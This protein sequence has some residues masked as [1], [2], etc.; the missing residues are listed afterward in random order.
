MANKK[1]TILIVL[2][3]FNIFTWLI[4]YNYDR[5]Q[6]LEVIFFD[7][8]QGDAV[9]IETPLNYQILIDGG[10]SSAILNKLGKEID[11]W[12]RTIDLI[13]L[14][15]PEHDHIAG[16]IEVLKRYNVENILWTGVLRDTGEYDEWTRL[17][18]DSNVEIAQ[19]GQKI[20]APNIFFE[21]LYPFENLEGQ[22]VKNTNNS[23]IVSRLVFNDTCFIFTGDIYSSVERKIIDKQLD[24]DCEVLKIGH[25]GSKTS[26]SK[27]L[28][29]NVTPQIAVISAGKD[30][31]YG[32]PHD[33]VLEILTDY[34]IK[35]LR[36]DQLGDIK[37]IS[38]GDNVT[39]T[40]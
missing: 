8:G 18:E 9:F 6:L 29:E 17:I 24:L 30:N 31:S 36:T 35:V 23:S 32:H 21:I 25:H 12:D 28:L 2:L 4:I 38:D 33:K 5:P 20:I 34:D 14:T 19:L 1:K 39:I 37:I 15:H 13:I 10:P 27:E 40:D 3:F 11:F 16:L 22:I 7:I 26:T